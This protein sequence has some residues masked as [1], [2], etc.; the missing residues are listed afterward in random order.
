[1]ERMAQETRAGRRLGK[2]A[3]NDGEAIAQQGPARFACS[4]RWIL[5]PLNSLGCFFLSAREPAA[6]DASLSFLFPRPRTRDV[7]GM[8]ETADVVVQVG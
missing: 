5:P 6:G 4:R 7:G 3:G 1:M 2:L 8:H